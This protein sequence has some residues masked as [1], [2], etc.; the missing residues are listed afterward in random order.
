MFASVIQ[1]NSV[2]AA[3]PVKIVDRDTD[4]KNPPLGSVISVAAL[5]QQ[6]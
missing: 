6:V 2:P 5:C 4:K 1:T 3:T